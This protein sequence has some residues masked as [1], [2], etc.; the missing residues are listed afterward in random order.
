MKKSDYI[1]E[2]KSQGCPDCGTNIEIYDIAVDGK[3]GKY[4]CLNLNCKRDTVWAV[5]E[6]LTMQQLLEKMQTKINI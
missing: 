1:A 3:S 6:A 4:R 2:M 5:G